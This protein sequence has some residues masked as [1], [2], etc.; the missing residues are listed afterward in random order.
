MS[1]HRFYFTFGS[2]P[3][4]PFGRDDY[5][6]VEAESANQA[7]G[8]FQAV[9]PNRFGSPCVN[10][11]AWYSEEAFN[12]FRDKY[13]QGIKPKEYISLLVVRN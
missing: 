5:V 2:D 13:Y 3:A 10:C 7:V 6:I 8:I 9:H 11:A 12:K 4:F 1:K